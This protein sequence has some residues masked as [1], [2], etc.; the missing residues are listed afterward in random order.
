MRLGARAKM[1]ANRTTAR[2]GTQLAPAACLHCPAPERQ[3][4]PLRLAGLLVLA[5]HARITSLKAN[6]A[7]SGGTSQEQRRRCT[8]RTHKRRN[9]WQSKHREI[10]RDC[11]F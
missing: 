9:Q 11:M 5:V 2:G 7:Y 6:C 10:G 1:T 4:A 3:S 8:L